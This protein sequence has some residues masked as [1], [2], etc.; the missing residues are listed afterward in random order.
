MAPRE[1]PV[2]ATQR[3]VARGFLPEG[4]RGRRADREGPSHCRLSI[5]A[6]TAAL[7]RRGPTIA[8]AGYPKGRSNGAPVARCVMI[9]PA[10]VASSSVRAAA[11]DPG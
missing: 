2:A 6:S 3:V 9:V 4:G 7:I 10:A 11:S 5:L 8:A 1:V